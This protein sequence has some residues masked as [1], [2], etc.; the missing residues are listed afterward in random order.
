[1]SGLHFD[2]IFRGIPRGIRPHN[3]GHIPYRANIF[4][5]PG[6]RPPGLAYPDYRHN[7]HDHSEFFALPEIAHMH[8]P[9]PFQNFVPQVFIP[10]VQ[11]QEDVPMP[12]IETVIFHQIPNHF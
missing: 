10:P 3:R 4:Y 7:I 6:G 8:P 12:M 11:Q 1:M 5:R 9:R 2:P